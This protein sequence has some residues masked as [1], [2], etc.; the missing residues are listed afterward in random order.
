M[1]TTEDAARAAEILDRMDAAM[2]A[3]KLLTADELEAAGIVLRALKGL[4]A[5][6]RV[7]AWV[8]GGP[9]A[10]TK[11]HVTRIEVRYF[12][13]GSPRKAIKPAGEPDLGGS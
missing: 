2:V 9:V 7:E 4:A 12:V 1:I 10:L 5:G 3:E 6:E 8:E 13:P 11:R